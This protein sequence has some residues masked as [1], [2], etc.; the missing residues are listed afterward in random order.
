VECATCQVQGMAT[1]GINLPSFFIYYQVWA[2]RLGHGHRQPVQGNVRDSGRQ[3]PDSP[4]LQNCRRV[5]SASWP[6]WFICSMSAYRSRS[7]MSFEHQVQT[8]LPYPQTAYAG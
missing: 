2:P 1:T 4:P 6:E 5:S 8:G 7:L 3:G